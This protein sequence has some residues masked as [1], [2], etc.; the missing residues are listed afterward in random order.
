MVAIPAAAAIPKAV[1]GMSVA[2]LH[3]ALCQMGG[4][5]HRCFNLQQGANTASSSLPFQ[6]FSLVTLLPLLQHS[7]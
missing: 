2:A 5:K 7:S 6:V 3:E 1:R 4:P